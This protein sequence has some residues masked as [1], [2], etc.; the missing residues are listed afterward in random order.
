MNGINLEILC[1]GRYEDDLDITRRDFLD[2]VQDKLS[3]RV[4]KPR[5]NELFID[6]DSKEDLEET[7]YRI[8]VVQ[9]WTEVIKEV[10]ITPS[11]SKECYHVRVLLTLDTLTPLERI[12]MQALLN[13]DV[14][15]EFLS[16]CRHLNGD[17]DVTVFF[18]KVY[19]DDIT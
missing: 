2:S 10:T 1:H 15:R 12:G 4:D 18:E 14:K 5:E 16:M 6:V 13:S 17:D 9:E 8:E 11:K 7:K 19:K 3:L